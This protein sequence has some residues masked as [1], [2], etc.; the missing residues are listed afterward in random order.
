MSNSQDRCR[1]QA[2]FGTVYQGTDSG[3]FHGGFRETHPRMALA[4]V[5][6]LLTS[7]LSFDQ[8]QKW[9][10]DLGSFGCAASPATVPVELPAQ[11]TSGRKVRHRRLQYPIPSPPQLPG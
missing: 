4:T 3:S 11:S 5:K 9:T 7:K 6:A 1:R 10:D 2:A 8:L